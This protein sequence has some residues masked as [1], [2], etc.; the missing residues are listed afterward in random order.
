MVSEN[1]AN[2]LKIHFVFAVGC[3][4]TIYRDAMRLSSFIHDGMKQMRNIEE[5]MVT[6]LNMKR[7]RLIT[8]E[9]MTMKALNELSITDDLQSLFEDLRL[10]K[11]PTEEVNS[12]FFPKLT[13]A[14][15]ELVENYDSF[16]SECFSSFDPFKISENEQRAGMKN[17][18]VQGECVRVT[19]MINDSSFSRP[20]A[21]HAYN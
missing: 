16:H 13:E 10:G 8:N 19:F 20:Y 18:F 3:Y 9:A 6:V 15:I 14:E 5:V 12:Y 4:T 1:E 11:R 17:E 7:V 21:I 2:G